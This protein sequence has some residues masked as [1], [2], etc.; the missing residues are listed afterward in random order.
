MTAGPVYTPYSG[1]TRPFAIGLKPLDISRWIEVD[2]DYRA[3]V[4]EKDVLMAEKP[5]EVFAAEPDTGEAQREVLDL[6]TGDLSTRFRML[7]DESVRR[8]GLDRLAT[9]PLGPEEA[10]LQRAGRLVQEDL[11]L[12]RRGSDGWRLA[13]G[14]L[15][16]PSAWSLPEKFGK[17]LPTVH[18]PVPGFGQG[19]RNAGMIER[20]FD[21]LQVSQPVERLNWSLQVEGERH[22]ATLEEARG[23]RDSSELAPDEI[24]EALALVYMRIERQTFRKLAGTGDI[25]FTIRTY[26]DP[27]QALRQHPE[28]KQLAPSFA[29]QIMELDD[30]QLQYKG[31][32]PYR[33]ALVDELERIAAC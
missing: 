8:F 28:R 22:V 17:P 2:G 33:Q 19:S 10:D 15:C 25:L 18:G 31:L 32:G 12:M 14:S 29:R 3:Y 5:L 30:A 26:L 16:F 13:A 4:E 27:M 9:V 11:L 6:V 21:N 20:I 1:Q 7:D 23:N 24:E